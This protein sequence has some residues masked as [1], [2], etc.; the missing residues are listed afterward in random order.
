M[1]VFIFYLIIKEE[2]LSFRD[3]FY[4]FQAFFDSFTF[5]IDDEPIH[6]L[7]DAIIQS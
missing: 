2:M 7:A 1:V 6:L 5:F 3:F 4:Q